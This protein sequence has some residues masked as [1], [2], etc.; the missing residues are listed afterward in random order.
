MD[1]EALRTKALQDS[2]AFTYKSRF[3]LFSHAVSTAVGDN[4]PF[5]S[6]LRK[7]FV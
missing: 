7:C 6:G 1:K 5:Q 4:G 3:G 2:D